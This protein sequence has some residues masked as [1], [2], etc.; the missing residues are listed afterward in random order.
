M[1]H[2]INMA[3]RFADTLLLMKEGRIFAAG[4][5]EEVLSAPLLSRLYDWPLEK[6]SDKAGRRYFFS[7]Q[8]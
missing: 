3:A 2:D 8:P 5:Q 6:L 4:K 7:G 1:I